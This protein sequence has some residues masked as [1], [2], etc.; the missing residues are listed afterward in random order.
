[1]DHAFCSYDQILTA[2]TPCVVTDFLTFTMD[3]PA[4]TGTS[5]LR[6]SQARR[7]LGGSQA[8]SLAAAACPA[9]PDQP[10]A[11]ASARTR[12]GPRMCGRHRGIDHAP[13]PEGGQP[14]PGGLAGRPV[15]SGRD[16]PRGWRAL[17]DPGG[18]CP[19]R[20][21][22]LDP[23]PRRIR[24]PSPLALRPG[25]AG[26]GRSRRPRYRPCGRDPSAPPAAAGPRPPRGAAARSRRSGRS[27]WGRW[28]GPWRSARRT[29]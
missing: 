21:A 26:C 27:P 18:P 19:G 15:G 25:V 12:R 28:D 17:P 1:M 8:V 16:H 5:G 4:Q 24:V 9:P 11:A 20:Q 22:V 29:D 10:V 6:P 3:R 14:C 2:Q 7:W 13:E 23:E